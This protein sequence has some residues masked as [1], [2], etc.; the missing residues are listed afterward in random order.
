M[1]RLKIFPLLPLLA[2]LCVL[3]GSA[4]AGAN[5]PNVLFIA[6]DDQNDWIGCMGGHPQVKT[7]NI[8][9]L[10]KRGTL[11]LNAHCQ[12]PLCNPSRSS[13]LTGLRPSSTGIYGLQPGIRDVEQ[14]K[15]HVTLPQTFTSAGYHTF[16][17]G[18][19]YHSGSIK[20]KDQPAEFNTWARPG[21]KPR[22]PKPFAN[23]P[24]PRH[25]A[26]DW[27]AWPER[28]EDAPDYA[29]ASAAIEALKN[30]PKDK[31][32]FI[33]A[34]FALPHVPCYAPQRW[35]DLYPDATLQMPPVL[36]ND[37][38]DTPRFSWY[39]HW[40]LPEPR[41]HTLKERNEWRPLVRAYLASTSFMDAQLGRVL[42]ALEATGRADNTIVVVWGDHGWHLGEKAITGK[43][44]LWDRSTRVPFIFAGP[45]VAK[46]AKCGRPVELLD[47]FPTLL[48]M[49]GFP[50]R[51]DLEGH[52]LVPQL[53]NANAPREWPAITTHN[54]DNHGIR[55]ERWRY[56]HYADGSEELY[57]MK[58]DPNEWKNLAG[59]KKF[60]DVKR[61]MAK[62]LPKVNKKPV[63]DSAARILLYDAKTG[64][65]NWEGKDVGKS[66]PI[67]D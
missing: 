43:N 55:T 41:L 66:E 42:D 14:T 8:D 19:I 1:S 64:G 25:P 57:D 31:P 32:F 10:A 24:E 52:S 30:A 20:P 26:M 40:K 56:I 44:T 22:P 63:P 34:G 15:N 17:A 6:I 38:D 37:R 29:V 23:L 62:W 50:A 11:F 12:A 60:A 36:E 48:E 27:G 47:I 4:S 45:G 16:N 35:F 18:K 59:D 21:G 61:D 5:K 7:P 13:L 67:P 28:D 46:A 53:K 33:A 9:R 58:A 39:L 54:H 51:A 49:A 65:V 2:C 3:G